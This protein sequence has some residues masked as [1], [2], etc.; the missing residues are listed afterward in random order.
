MSYSELLDNKE[1]AIQ[2]TEQSDV[3][4]LSNKET[5]TLK[6][7]GFSKKEIN[8]LKETESEHLTLSDFIGFLEAYDN[9]SV[10]PDDLVPSEINLHE[11]RNEEDFVEINVKPVETVY[12]DGEDGNYKIFY[13]KLHYTVDVKSRWYSNHKTSLN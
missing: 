12:V 8:A 4:S 10:N 1:Q 7:L 9:K 2:V 5:N 11:E 6:Q 13:T 3:E